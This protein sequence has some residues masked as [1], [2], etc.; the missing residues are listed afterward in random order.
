MTQ[1][2]DH[3][4]AGRRRRHKSP[5]SVPPIH[6][7]L[8]PR[9]LDHMGAEDGPSCSEEEKVQSDNILPL[10]HLDLRWVPFHMNMIES[11]ELPQ[12]VPTSRRGLEKEVTRKQ[13]IPMTR[14]LTTEKMMIGLLEGEVDQCDATPGAGEFHGVFGSASLRECVNLAAQS[15]NAPSAPCHSEGSVRESPFHIYSPPQVMSP[16]VEQNLP[17]DSTSAHEPPSNDATQRPKKR[18]LNEEDLTPK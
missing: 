3:P 14:R 9:L 15:T 5:A 12:W 1:Q 17:Q 4:T 6:D 11:W 8:L 13:K 10:R 7:L 2:P 16:N 18:E